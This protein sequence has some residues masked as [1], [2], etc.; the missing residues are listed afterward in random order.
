MSLIS[1]VITETAALDTSVPALKKFGVT[2]GLVLT[3]TGT[4]L[5]ILHPALA[6]FLMGAAGVLLVTGG[7]L[8]TPYLKPLYKSWMALSLALGWVSSRVLLIL[9]FYLLLMPVGILLRAV[10]KDFMAL[11]GKHG[12]TSAWRKR[13]GEINYEKLY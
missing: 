8:F 11:R 6:W 9:L 5:N 4:L 3:A 13:H 10:G 7:I 2:V 1:D 12:A